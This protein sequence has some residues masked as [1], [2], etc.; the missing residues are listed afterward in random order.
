MN[1][2]TIWSKPLQNKAAEELN[3]GADGKNLIY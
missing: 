1:G 2:K 3:T